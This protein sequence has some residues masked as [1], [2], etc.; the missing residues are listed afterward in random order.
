MEVFNKG[1]VVRVLD[2]VDLESEV[3]GTVAMIE[4]DN[5]IEGLYWLYIIAN[6]EGYNTNFD[7]RIG[8]YWGIFEMDNPYIS[9]VHRV[10]VN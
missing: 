7:P 4:P 1:D 6:Y 5:E 3:V 8:N 2:K 9:L 10:T